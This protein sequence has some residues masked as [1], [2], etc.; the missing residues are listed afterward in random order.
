MS[1]SGKLATM[2]REFGPKTM[3]LLNEFFGNPGEGGRAI[4]R[5]DVREFLI[6]EFNTIEGSYR[7]DVHQK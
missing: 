1:H 6:K 4:E 2:N 5:A 7:E 3:L